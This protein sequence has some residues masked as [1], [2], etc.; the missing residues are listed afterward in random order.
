ML[1][2]HNTWSL[3]YIYIYIFAV[4]TKYESSCMIKTNKLLVKHRQFILETPRVQCF[5]EL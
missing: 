1:R 2:T 4:L 3:V 5:Y